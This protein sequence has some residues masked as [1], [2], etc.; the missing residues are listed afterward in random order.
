MKTMTFNLTPEFWIVFH[1]MVTLVLVAVLFHLARQLK[2]LKAILPRE[3][4]GKGME[5]ETVKK[6]ADK[7]LTLLEPLLN[8]AESAARIFESQIMEKKILIRDLNDKL[9]SR[10]I[11]LNLL[12]NRADAC[13]ST[14]SFGAGRESFE[15][16]GISDMQE[17]ILSLFAQGLDA[18]TISDTLSVSRKEVDLVISLKRKF[19]AM[20]K[21][22]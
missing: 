10:I 21:E 7:V 1:M 22:T 6:A 19:I 15:G 13:L 5:D 2:M 18:T 16:A 11:S 3:T 9:D 17:A 4:P 14:K 8:E 20:E 12:L